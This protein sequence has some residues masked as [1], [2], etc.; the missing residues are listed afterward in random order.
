MSDGTKVIH[1]YTD[2]LPFLMRPGQEPKCSNI[3]S[4]HIAP[5]SGAEKTEER[6]KITRLLITRQHQTVASTKVVLGSIS[7]NFA[8]RCNIFANDYHHYL[9]YQQRL[10]VWAVAGNYNDI[11]Q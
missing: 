11:V 10:T 3:F 7:V 5:K 9:E 2:I 8:S 4:E 6:G 1:A